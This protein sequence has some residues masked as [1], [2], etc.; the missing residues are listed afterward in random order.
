MCENVS[1]ML[2]KGTRKN[3]KNKN[4]QT[5]KNKTPPSLSMQRHKRP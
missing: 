3:S 1:R 2:T 5:N 4:K